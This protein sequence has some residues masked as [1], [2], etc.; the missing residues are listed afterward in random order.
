MITENGTQP[1][2]IDRVYWVQNVVRLRVF[3]WHFRLTTRHSLLMN[4]SGTG[5]H[6]KYIQNFKDSSG[7]QFAISIILGLSPILVFKYKMV[8]GVAIIESNGV[9]FRTYLLEGSFDWSKCGK[10]ARILELMVVL[11]FTLNEKE[12][13]KIHCKERY[14]RNEG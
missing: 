1:R 14:W 9:H 7:I 11:L 10:V 4:Q 12:T 13:K 5:F 6:H 2:Q 8:P 3:S